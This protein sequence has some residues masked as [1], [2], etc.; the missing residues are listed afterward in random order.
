MHC[1]SFVHDSTLV[2]YT[3]HAYNF[4]ER[5]SQAVHHVI[6]GKSP[7]PGMAHPLR[8]LPGYLHYIASLNIFY[9]DIYSNA[10]HCH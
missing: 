4:S 7:M 2:G 8:A 6:K 10:E 3:S 9:C 1:S 5:A